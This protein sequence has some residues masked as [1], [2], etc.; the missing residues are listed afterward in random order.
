MPKRVDSN[1]KE[2]VKILR[3][4]GASVCHLHEVCKGCPDI[5][6]GF[7]KTNYL[8]EIKNPDKP[9]SERRLTRDEEVWHRVWNGQVDTVMA[10]YDIIE[11][12]KK[13]HGE[14]I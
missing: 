12:L 7:R 2:I 1:Q 4:K 6:V 11:I 3:D 5:L 10:A 9:P 13:K 8:F 14:R